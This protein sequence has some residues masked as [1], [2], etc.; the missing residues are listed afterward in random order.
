MKKFLTVFLTII[1]PYAFCEA[2]IYEIPPGKY[3][4][5][6]YPV[7]I[8]EK[9]NLQGKILGHLSMIDEF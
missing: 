1:A 5:L 8:R 4:V 6:D 2:L 3:Y 7:N 9:P